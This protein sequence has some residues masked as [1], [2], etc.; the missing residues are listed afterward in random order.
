MGI[1]LESGKYFSQLINGEDFS[2]EPTDFTPALSG[3]VVDL[4]KTIQTVRLFWIAEA[5]G[6]NSFNVLAGNVI[7]REAGDFLDDQFSVGDKIEMW[8]DPGVGGSDV[9]TGEREVLSIS[10]DTMIVD[11]AAITPASYDD[12]IIYGKTLQQAVRYKYGLIGN[13]ESTN[14]V[15]K[16]DGTAENSFNAINVGVDTGG[17]VT[18]QRVMS[19]QAGVKSFIDEGE[20]K[21]NY[22]STLDR[23]NN[24]AQVFV[25]DHVFEVLPDALD[26]QQ[27]N[28]T[29]GTPTPLYTSTNSIKHVYQLLFSDAFSNPAPKVITIDYINGNLGW[30]GESGNGG[31]PLFNINSITYEGVASGQPIAEIDSQNQTEVTISL[32]SVNSKFLAST[33]FVVHIEYIPDEDDYQ[34]NQ[35]TIQENFLSDRV[36]QI[37]GAAVKAGTIIS[38]V[39]GQFINV[40]EIIVTFKTDYTTAQSLAVKDRNYKIS[41]T[42]KD[43]DPLI[44]HQK[45]DQ[46]AILCDSRE[47][48]FTTD[49]QNLVFVDNLQIFPKDVLDF[50]A[51][52]GDYKGWVNDSLSC[53]ARVRLNIDEAATIV[54]L[55]VSISAF[56]DSTGDRFDLNTYSFDMSQSVVSGGIQQINIDANRGFELLDTGTP[57]QFNKAELGNAGAGIV[58]LINTEDYDLRLGL[59]INFEDQILQP[60]ADTIFYDNTQLNDGLNKRLSNYMSNGYKPKL[61]FDLDIELDGITTTYTYKAPDW[62]IYF[63]EEDGNVPPDWAVETK[64]YDT[65]GNEVEEVLLNENTKVVSTF[66]PDS[67]ATNFTGKEWAWFHLYIEDQGTIFN[68]DEYFNLFAN[69]PGA[70]IPIPGETNI[71][72]TDFGTHLTTEISIDFTQLG[73]SPAIYCIESRLS[74]SNFIAGKL[75]SSGGILKTTSGGLVK[76]LS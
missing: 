39:E 38:D 43:P 48:F 40:N 25:L 13:S 50:N 30:Y 65:L 21:I 3:S 70:F 54:S 61:I 44:L 41:V 51:G 68:T 28:L 2:L 19:P 9:L 5:D 34:Q 36:Y 18:E 67:G 49:V 14:F 45:T 26:G 62:E 55:N 66:T 15:S 8:D 7:E 73:G 76:T 17:G 35:N 74:K 63:F 60:D 16:V 33:P 47:Y 32:D 46:V 53:K 27:S 72:I 10:S 1:I 57:E 64:L 69:L 4:K 37:T 24:Y 23:A 42:T 56:N 6:I 29:S 59:K 11:G 75:T 12:A 52:Y 31:Q 58:G 22:D 71:K 20:V